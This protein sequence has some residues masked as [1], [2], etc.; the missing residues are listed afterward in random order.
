VRLARLTGLTMTDLNLVLTTC[1]AG[2]IDLAALRAIAAV[3]RLQRNHDLTATEVCSLAGAAE[4]AQAEGCSG[5]ILAARNRDYRFRL[6]A[7]ID[8]AESDIVGVVRRYRARYSTREPSPFDRGDVGLPAIALLRRA[9]R[10]AKALGISVDE[11]FDV[12]VALESDPSLHRYTTFAVLGDAPAPT[13]D[14]Y[15]MLEGSD[16]GATL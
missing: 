14:Y 5:D 12:L 7:A 8:V 2:R 3:I 1:C 10:L 4:L 9:G 6:A 16:P 13:R 11:L 15:R